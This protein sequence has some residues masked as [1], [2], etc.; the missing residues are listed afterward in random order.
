MFT[1]KPS[2]LNPGSIIELYDDA[3]RKTYSSGQYKTN[4]LGLENGCDKK[5]KILPI[6][7]VIFKSSG[8]N[9][10]EIKQES[11]RNCFLISCLRSIYRKYP[12]VLS[13][14]ITEVDNNY[15]EVRL[16]GTDGEKIVYKIEKTIVVQESSSLFRSLSMFFFHQQEA[17]WI[18][19]IEKAFVLHVMRTSYHVNLRNIYNNGR[20]W[21]DNKSVVPSYEDVLHVAGNDWDILFPTFLGCKVS[22]YFYNHNKPGQ[23]IKDMFA[24]GELVNVDF[25]END[26][27]FEEKHAYELVNFGKN[28][29]EDEY[30]V[31]SNPWG[32]NL[33]K[34]LFDY[35]KFNILT[36]KPL[37]ECSWKE[38]TNDKGCII[39]PMNIFLKIV[40]SCDVTNGASNV[41]NKIKVN[42]I[43]PST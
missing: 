43:S 9:L 15:V 38:V 30:V 40:K 42:T 27:G 3:L 31:L 24:S 20:S 6:V 33:K 41:I 7:G 12:E 14:M 19:L 11:S 21:L 34:S 1:Q 4:L 25:L 22:R 32:V 16:F 2:Q 18:K 26:Y 13:S 23:N 17:S 36:L 8:I 37:I 39:V 28:E 10:S 35:K 5:Y 29:Y